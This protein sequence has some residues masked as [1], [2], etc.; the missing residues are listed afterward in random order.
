VEDY[1]AALTCER[2]FI[3]AL[4]NRAL[5]E[6]ELGLH[7]PALAD[8]DRVLALGR[9][10][11]SVRAGRGISLEGLGR[12]KGA[13]AEFQAALERATPGP[14]RDRLLWA[15]GFAVS[16]RL[17]GRAGAAFEEVLRREPNQPQARYGC[18]M[19]AMRAG[20]LDEALEAFNLALKADPGFTEARRYRAIVL[21]RRGDWM[22]AGQE[23]NRC[24]EREPRHPATLYAAACVAAVAA[25]GTSDRQA[26]EQALDLLALA[27]D[28]GHELQKAADDPDL[29]SLR[30]MPRFN[31]LLARSD[32]VPSRDDAAVLPSSRP[33][34]EPAEPRARPFAERS[35][36]PDADHD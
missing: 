6:V 16:D 21:A 32:P 14:E 19:L 36:K 3:P 22:Q 8:F 26:A 12:H 33:S 35:R 11:P 20:R 30:D 28:H 7:A 31:R 23:I 2:D 1:T 10:D 17:P 5:A 24:L 9:D 18:A 27:R 4:L 29:A 15:Y 34:R 25:R 13:D